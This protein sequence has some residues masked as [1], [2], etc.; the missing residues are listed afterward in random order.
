MKEIGIA[1]TAIA[2]ATLGS[3]WRGYVLSVLWA[4]FIVTTFGAKPL[5]IAAAIGV[6]CVVGFLTKQYKPSPK[7]TRPAGEQWTD[8]SMMIFGGP[9]GVLLFG[10]IVKA[11]L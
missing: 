10:Y 8:L 2:I 9:A 4:W 7:D 5:S 11:W 3:I 6:S 1:T